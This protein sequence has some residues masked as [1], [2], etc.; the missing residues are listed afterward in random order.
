MRQSDVDKRGGQGRSFGMNGS[1][2]ASGLFSALFVGW[3]AGDASCG[4]RKALG[5][6]MQRRSGRGRSR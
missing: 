1:A 5:G 4:V 3:V 2:G 6:G